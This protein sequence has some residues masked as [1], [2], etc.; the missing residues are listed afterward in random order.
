VTL[1]RVKSRPPDTLRTLVERH[2]A[3]SF[4]PAAVE[5]VALYQSEPGKDGPRYTVLAQA[6]LRAAESRGVPH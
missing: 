6:A 2:A 4:G 1:A 3:T 5:S